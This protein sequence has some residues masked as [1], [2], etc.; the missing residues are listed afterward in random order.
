ML[1][2]EKSFNNVVFS[3]PVA[4]TVSRVLTQPAQSLITI[5][6]RHGALAQQKKYNYKKEH[7]VR[8]K[9]KERKRERVYLGSPRKRERKGD[10][11]RFHAFCDG[12]TH[13][14]R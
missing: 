6:T 4:V 9:E 10:A 2:L 1:T 12:A 8:E 7:A 14:T 5:D 3:S 11:G 13:E